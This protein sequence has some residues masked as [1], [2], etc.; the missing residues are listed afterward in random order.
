MPRKRSMIETRRLDS[1]DDFKEPAIQTLITEALASYGRQD[2]T[3][4]ELVTLC[5]SIV[6]M[7]TDINVAMWAG[8]E[9][10]VYKSFILLMCPTSPFE[11]PQVVHWHNKGSPLLKR[12]MCAELVDFLRTRGYN[13]CW[14]VNRTGQADST[15]ARGLRTIGKGKP[16]GSIVSFEVGGERR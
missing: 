12:S 3:D 7:A 6:S 1:R 2:W 8:G 13:S 11:T 16:I 15:W 9:D 5:K 4:Q 14:I 10:E